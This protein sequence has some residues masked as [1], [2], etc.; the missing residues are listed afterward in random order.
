MKEGEENLQRER[1][2]RYGGCSA[3]GEDLDLQGGC[4]AVF[5]WRRKAFMG[6]SGAE[7]TVEREGR[8]ERW[9]E[10]KTEE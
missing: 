4:A 8:K 10:K 1:D 5:W 2:R 9:L 3:T 6:S 7:E